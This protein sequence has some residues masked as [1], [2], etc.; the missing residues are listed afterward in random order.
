MAG[1]PNL[2]R[3]IR[4]ALYQLKHQFGD[5]VEV[6]RGESMKTAV[7]TGVK[8]FT[9]SSFTVRK[10]I[11]APSNLQRR[12]FASISYISASKPFVSSGGPGWDAEM[13]T[14]IFDGRDI[15]MDYQIEK[16]DW[17]VYRDKRY[18]ISVVEQLEFNAGWLVGGNVVRG[19]DAGPR[20]HT[21]NTHHHMTFDNDASEE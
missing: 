21:K 1:N 11:V 20:I 10:C 13:T 17:L 3:M 7:T 19:Q 9:L 8:T 12:I 2:N 18:D 14:F 5:T 4:Q 6:Y 16:E 15:P